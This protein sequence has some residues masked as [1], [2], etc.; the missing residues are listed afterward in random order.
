MTRRGS[1]SIVANPVLVGAVTTLVTVVAVFLAYNANNG[2]P[3]VPTRQLK[4]QVPNGAALLPGN[5]VREGGYRIGV[6]EDMK[7]VRMADGQVG[8]EAVLKL[9]DKAGAVPLD[10]HVVI[11]PRSVLG[12]K[13]VELTRGRSKQTFKNGDTLPIGQTRLPVDL[14]RLY[15]IFDQ[16]TRD[17]SQENLRGFGDTLARRGQSLNDTIAAAPRFLRHLQPVMTV[18]GARDTDFA[19]FWKELGDAAR[20]VAPVADAYAHGFTSGADTFE[21]WSRDPVALQETIRRSVP[22]L[23]SGIRSFPVQRSFLRD[24]ARF[25]R[26]LSRAAQEMPYALPRI[27]PA[28]QVGTPVLRRTP[29]INDELRKTLDQA[30][31]LFSN[32]GTGMALRGLIATVTTL[33]PTLRFVGPYVTVCNYFNY[34]WT[35][36]GEHIS[37]PDPTGTAQRTLLN[38]APRHDNSPGSIGAT[39]PATGKN[40]I[41]GTPANLHVNVYTA[42]IDRM[43]NADCESGQRGYIRKANAYGTDD[44]VVDPHIP[45][46]QGPTFTG[47]P[48]VLPGQTFTRTP[49]QGPLMPPELDR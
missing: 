28:L 30:R 12:L 43:G 2:L 45:G 31:Q 1:G 4:V 26:S 6:V 7:P 47:R 16:P 29:E 20:V 32:P 37:E 48:R 18:L 49:Q 11:R 39:Q 44:I 33:N 19:R 38:Q 35:N 27:T 36:A 41:S 21:A 34:A 5:D 14:D 9:D 8:A 23:D 24:F 13:Y 46:N 40:P 10:S 3:F 42:A 25:S 17:A 15:D 22:T